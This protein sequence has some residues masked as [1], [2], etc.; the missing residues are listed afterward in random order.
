MIETNRKI[1]HAGKL[2]QFFCA[3]T[4]IF[5]TIATPGLRTIP[6]TGFYAVP[7]TGPVTRI[8]SYPDKTFLTNRINGMR[9]PELP[10]YSIV[11]RSRR[12]TGLIYIILQKIVPLRIT[13]KLEVLIVESNLR[14]GEI[15][16]EPI[17]ELIHR[18]RMLAERNDTLPVVNDRLAV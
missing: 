5:C 13:E 18:P 17:R 2:D 8:S 6:S 16:G 4:A 15:N 11:E 9:L 1:F 3:E 10:R 14:P 7:S 12:A